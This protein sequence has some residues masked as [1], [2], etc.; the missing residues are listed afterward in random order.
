MAT[1]HMNEIDLTPEQKLCRDAYVR[2][3]QAGFDFGI[4]AREFGVDSTAAEF[5]V[6]SHQRWM[7]DN[8]IDKSAGSA[9]DQTLAKF[10]SS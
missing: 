2:Y 3:V 8:S 7:A 6:R 5:L 10:S 1:A 4:L 9:F